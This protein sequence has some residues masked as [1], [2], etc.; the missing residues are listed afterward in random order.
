MALLA[1]M[2]ASFA[3]STTRAHAQV[4]VPLSVFKAGMGSGTVTSS[5]VGI[6]CGH[7]CMA[8]YGAR[9]WVTLY[10][11]ADP[12][13]SFAGWSGHCTGTSSS[14]DVFVYV[15]SSVTATFNVTAMT[16][17]VTLSKSGTGMG[18]VSSNP[19]GLDC[20]ELLCTFASA[21]F[22][23]TSAVT[24]TAKATSGSVFT[25]WSGACSGTSRSC[26]IPAGTSSANVTA[27]FDS[28]EDLTVSVSRQGTGSGTVISSPAGI[29]CDSTCTASYAAG[30]QVTLTALPASGSSFAG[31]SG[32]CFSKGSCTVSMDRARSVTATFNVAATNRWVTLSKSGTGTGSVSS[33]PGGLSCAEGCASTSANFASTS[34]VTLTAQ[35]AAGSGF[36]GWS[37]AC[38]G[39]SNSCTIPPGTSSANVTVQFNSTAVQNHTLTVSLQGAGSG[40]ITSSPVGINCGGTCSASYAAGAQVT[41]TA[42]PASGSNF[43]GWSGVCSGTGNCTVSMDSARSVTATFNVTVTNRLVTLSKSGSGT[44]SVSSNPG[45]LSCAEGCASTSSS[46][47]STSAVTLTAQADGGSTFAGWSGA[48]IG[49]S[50]SCTILPGTSSAN[51]AAQFNSTAVQNHTLSVWRQGVGSG[52]ITS[53][54]VGINCG[55]TCSASYAAGAQVTLTAQPASGSSFAGWGGACSGTGTCTVGMDSARSV[56]ATFNVTVTNR[57][58]TLSKSGSGTGSVTSSPSGLNCVEGCPSASASF[59]SAATVS[60]V[61]Q[62]AS[63]STF[64]GW[65]GACSGTQSYCTIPASSST[66]NVT[67]QF[68]TTTVQNHTLSVW[69][70][71]TGSGTVASTP[72]GIYCGSTC[73]ANYASG[74]QVILSA[75]AAT[76]STFTGWAGA[77]SGT[78]VC[79]VTVDAAKSVTAS[80]ALKSVV[81]GQNKR[82]AAGSYHT[83]FI[84]DD[85][86]LWAWG[87]ATGSV[88]PL[89]VG[90]GYTAVAAGYHHT[91]ALKTD[92]SL[93]AW[94]ANDYGQLGDGST[95]QRTSPIQIGTGYTAVVAGSNNTLA[96]KADGSLWAWGENTYGQLG[97]GSTI[98]RSSPVQIGAGYTAVAAGY[99]HTIGLKADGSLWAWG[100]SGYGQ[101]GD[102]SSFTQR[103]SPV[104]VGAGYTAV[105]AGFF[106]TLALKADSSLWAWGY[107]N[108][109]QLG[110]GSFTQ[111]THPVLVGTGYTA[112]AAARLHSLALKA[113]G[114]LWAWGVNDSGQLGDG[115]TTDRTTPIQVGTGYTMVTGNDHTLALKADGSLWAWGA[116]SAGQLGNGTTTS[117]T[118]PVLVNFGSTASVSLSVLKAGTG[119]GIVTSTPSG[120]Y[121]GITCTVNYAV[122]T[123]VTLTAQADAGSTFIGWG[124]ACSGTGSCSVSMASARSVTASFNA[125]P[126]NRLVTLSKSGTGTGS[127]TSAPS[128]L[129][130]A[131]DCPSAA[132]SF[133]SSATITLT[134]QAASGSTFVGWS[135]A[136]SGAYSDCTIPA[137]SSTANVTA[138]FNAI[139]VQNHALSV[140][141]QGTGSGTVTSTPSGIYCGNSCSAS[142]ASGTQVT[143]TARAASGSSFAGWGGACSGASETCNVLLDDVRSVTASF[144]TSN[145][146]G[147]LADPAAFVTQQYVDFLRRAPESATLNSWVSQLNT[148]TA[149]RAQVIQSLMNSSEF[150]GRFGPLVRL[151][152]AYFLRTP[153]YGGLMHWFNAMY[154]SGGYGSSLAQVSD[155]FAGSP[156]FVSRYGAL[157]SAGFVTLVYQNVLGRNPEAGGF[158]YWLGQLNAG[159][160][161]GQLMIGFSESAENQNATANAQ[162]ITLAYVAMLKRVP[163]ANEHAQW[164]ADMNAGRA[165]VLSLINSLLQ[166]AEYAARF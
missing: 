14:C 99:F 60:L 160:L 54:P 8:N 48:C 161:R 145:G 44:G 53:S 98:N 139:V 90:T 40:S 87:S 131:V 36:V 51:V 141:R 37:G 149:T 57:L 73:T 28:T 23:S 45:G 47:A 159:M 112:V 55:G 46:F 5:P 156:E 72:S 137:S 117:S 67:A 124:G 62:A 122:G 4:A 97:D 30:T 104:Q 1:L 92:G 113:D 41:L 59:A 154:P 138:Q 162:R 107:N 85:G 25:G 91:L 165:D 118:T 70:Q 136:C 133:A 9:S 21:R 65:S 110:D 7:T 11:L 10:A 134:A 153:D 31:W 56:T 96:L 152:T 82:L 166:S 151:Y 142:Y 163:N 150:Q 69:R 102:G 119:S 101:F 24:L 155:A 71:G 76:D 89:Q 140:W 146:G 93:W 126:S 103:T 6:N 158:T 127:V 135:G 75:Q 64:A 15:A 86:S 26:T 100:I 20:A 132:T 49:T 121:C 128:G 129:S 38:S 74:T 108:Y 116:N 147:P 95:T 58:I 3:L 111:R 114:S 2:L 81:I 83:A 34:A 19:S 143:L 84:R 63:G 61:A 66:A 123:Q 32:A 164:L 105:A 144:N 77:C 94:G 120:I 42:Q 157:D 130:C 80:F 43:V 109:G 17:I 16:R 125:A 106:H 27:Q 115:S 148:G 50:S 68:N 88:S 35:A 29:N 22:A 78:G 12:G 13:S 33:D 79:S 18:S 52:S 39:T